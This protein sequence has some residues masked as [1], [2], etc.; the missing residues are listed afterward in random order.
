MVFRKNSVA[1]ETQL[2]L[3]GRTFVYPE[4]AADRRNALGQR[5]SG[6]AF[7]DHSRSKEQRRPNRLTRRAE[8]LLNEVEK[9]VAPDQRLSIVADMENKRV[10]RGE[11]LAGYGYEGRWHWTDDM[12]EFLRNSKVDPQG[13]KAQIEERF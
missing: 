6:S 12:V 13:A 7:L 9:G 5:G 4:N 3:K 2:I 1:E 11:A 10:C 8:H